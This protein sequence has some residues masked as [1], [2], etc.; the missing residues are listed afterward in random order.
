MVKASPLDLLSKNDVRI[1]QIIKSV[2]DYSIEF[3]KDSFESLIRS[4][5]YQ[6]LAGK[7]ASAIFARFVKCYNPAFPTPKQIL[8]T[9]P[10]ILHSKAGLSFRKI[11]Y[12]TDLSMKIYTGQLD[13][14]SISDLGD[15]EVI[16]ELMKVRGIGRWTAE[17]FLIFRLK[18]EDVFPE[19]DLGIKKA[20]QVMYGLPHLPTQEFIAE[21]SLKWKPYRSVAAWYL[22]K[23]LNSFTLIG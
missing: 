16:A 13:L 23:S 4:I 8:E 9:S 22:W 15:K 18:R 14:K 1:A 7:A 10:Q 2:G 12:I 19:T 3:H 11:E 17:M 5:V 21:A 20:I 6:Q